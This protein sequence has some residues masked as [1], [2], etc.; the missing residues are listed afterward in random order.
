MKIAIT[1]GMGFIGTEL[2]SR[3]ADGSDEITVVDFWDSLLRDYESARYPALNRIYRN[4]S[5]AEQVITP[6]EFMTQLRESRVPDVIVHLGAIV[7]TTDLGSDTMIQENVRFTRTLVSVANDRP[8]EFVPGIVFASSAA[9]YGA[10]HLQPNNPYGLT[11]VL[12]EKV[13]SQTRG[14]YAML[15]L[16]NVFGALEHHKRGS[17]SL[18][19]KLAQAYTTGDLW[20]D[21]HSPH[22]SRDFVPV[23]SVADEIVRIATDMTSRESDGSDGIRGTW[24]VGTGESTLLTDMDTFIQQARRCSRSLVREV[25]IPKSIAGRYQSFTCA[26]LN[27]M[28]LIGNRMNTRDGIEE[29]YGIR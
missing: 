7:D 18:P 13:I 24:D 17:A 12:G 14:Q 1:G 16:F 5:I 11:K 8:T 23:T 15:R 9:T 10:N 27:G 29:Q 21:M 22:A 2:V 19:F 28:P 26:G 4:L 20:F 3:F 25:P 6:D